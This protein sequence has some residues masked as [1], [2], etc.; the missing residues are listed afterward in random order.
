LSVI[1]ITQKQKDLALKATH[2]PD[3]RI[4][5]L[6]SIICQEEWMAQAMWKI[7]HNKGAET[8][9]IDGVIRTRYYD[10]ETNSLKESARD[11]I[12][13]I[14][15]SLERWEYKPQPV[16]RTYI[17]KA[18]G[19]MRPIGIPTLDDRIV[20]EAIRMVLE[21]IYD[22]DFLDCSYGFRPKRSTMDA[23]AVCY[24]LINPS[25]KYY[26]VIEGDIKGCFD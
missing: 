2:N 21:P 6:Y 25:K 3:G 24:R 15:R 1:E 8:A 7:I 5:C 17:P 23:I 13:E 26:W 14:C 16:R 10:A 11:K 12:K 4:G 22:S 20:Q 9:G 18:N 19:K